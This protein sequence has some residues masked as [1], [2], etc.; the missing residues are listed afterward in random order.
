VSAHYAGR[1]AGHGYVLS[2]MARSREETRRRLTTAAI[3]VVSR[4]GYH[5]AS[6]NEIAR[7]AGY[8]I[9]ALYS[10]FGS[11]D[12]LLL[13]VFDEHVRWFEAQLDRAAQADDTTQATSDWIQSLTEKPDQFLVFIEF[14]AYAVRKP[15]MRREFATRMA[16]LRKRV[17]ATVVQRSG[18]ISSGPPP[19]VVA[20]LLLALGRG[21][22]LEKLVDPEAVPDQEVARLLAA[23][24]D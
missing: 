24:A 2:G 23:L 19:D 3:D 5:A 1:D 20:L 15:K 8:S 14:W 7:R 18:A 4:K 12:D 17:A 11:K 22:A 13:A 16:E 9:G 10:N 21:L 6:V